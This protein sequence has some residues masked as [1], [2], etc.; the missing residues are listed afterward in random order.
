MKK[1]KIKPLSTD[2]DVLFKDND[3]IKKVLNNNWLRDGSVNPFFGKDLP[4]V[5][6]DKKHGK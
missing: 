4:P 5:K 2:L 1:K 3:Q 6:K